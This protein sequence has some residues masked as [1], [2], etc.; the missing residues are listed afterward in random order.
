MR[1]K[2]IIV[3]ILF[4]LPL[5]LFACVGADPIGMNGAG[6][7]VLTENSKA[8]YWNPGL[9]SLVKRPE[10]SYCH[11][12]KNDEAKLVTRYDD[13]ASG[14]MAFGRVGVGAMY[15]YSI[16][17]IPHEAYEEWK[18]FLC[19]A[20]FQMY[21]S[22]QTMILAGMTTGIKETRSKTAFKKDKH[23]RGQMDYGIA[24]LKKSYIFK[25]DVFRIGTLFQTTSLNV[26]PSFSETIPNFGNK[27]EFTAA[28]S[29]YG[30]TGPEIYDV[31]RY[32]IKQILETGVGYFG[33][34][35]GMSEFNSDNEF[36]ER[37]FGISYEPLSESFKISLATI[38]YDEAQSLLIDFAKRF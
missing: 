5:S 8:V 19:S 31:T 11:S 1:I 7:E 16:R 20:G 34:E 18:S 25:N 37:A 38:Q 29:F 12:F 23:E 26:R 28:I 3:P 24:I 6:G 36:F 14:A 32:G 27:G 22:E 9:L 35:A 10:V 2:P 33:F 21:K 4:F 15:I 17:G 13:V 30:A